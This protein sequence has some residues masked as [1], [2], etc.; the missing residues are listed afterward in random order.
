M[1]ATTNETKCPGCGLIHNAKEPC[2]LCEWLARMTKL[3]AQR[4]RIGA[5]IQNSAPREK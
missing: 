2:W 1:N 4:K 5:F 3:L